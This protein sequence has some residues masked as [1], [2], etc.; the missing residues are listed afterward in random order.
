MKRM[1]WR[2]GWEKGREGRRD[3]GAPQTQ[4]TLTTN[5]IATLN[6]TREQERTSPTTHGHSRTVVPF[7]CVWCRASGP[8]LGVKTRRVRG[9]VGVCSS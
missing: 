2:G 1:R 9:R 5:A 8:W 4:V 6:A 7:S 3:S